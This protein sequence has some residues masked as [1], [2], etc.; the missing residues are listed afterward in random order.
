M[1]VPTTTTSQMLF[2]LPPKKLLQGSNYQKANRSTQVPESSLIFPVFLYVRF[3]HALGRLV[4]CGE[5]WSVKERGS[6]SLIFS[7]RLSEAWKPS[8]VHRIVGW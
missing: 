3:Y 2:C 6:T 4:D 5:G 7:R 8:P 1:R